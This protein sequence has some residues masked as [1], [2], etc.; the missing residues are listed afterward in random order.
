M[1]CLVYCGSTGLRVEH[2]LE[3]PLSFGTEAVVPVEIGMTSYRV[4]S[5]NDKENAEELRINLDLVDE[6]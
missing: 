6:L 4:E 5:F 2:P 1:S 3:R